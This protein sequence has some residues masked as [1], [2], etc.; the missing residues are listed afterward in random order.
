MKQSKKNPTK[1]AARIAAFK[2]DDGRQK[3]HKHHRPG[4]NKLK[5]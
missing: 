3:P 1:L 2:A 4:S 5:V